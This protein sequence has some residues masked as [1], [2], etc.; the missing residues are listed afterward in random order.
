M[1]SMGHTHAYGTRMVHGSK[2]STNYLIIV[3]II[4]PMAIRIILPVVFRLKTTMGRPLSR[5][6][7]M[8][9]AS[10]TP[11][12]FESTSK[13]EIWG[14]MTALGNLSGSMSYTPSTRVAL[15]MTWAL[16]SSARKVAAV[17]V[18]KYGLEVPPAKITMRPFSKWRMA[19]R[20]I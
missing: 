11:S 1:V 9:E 2:D 16:I 19:R 15:A 5:H 20:R 12:A 17:S 8:A 13:Y 14:Y 7:A 18:E 6:M 4:S 10:I 3:P